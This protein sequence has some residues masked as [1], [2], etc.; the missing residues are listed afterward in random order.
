M[1]NGAGLVEGMFIPVVIGQGQDPDMFM[2]VVDGCAVHGATGGTG[3][4]GDNKKFAVSSWQLA[5]LKINCQPLTSN[6]ILSGTSIPSNFIDLLMT[7]P[8]AADS[9]SR[10]CFTASFSACSI[11]FS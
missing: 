11:D 6:Y 1:V 10:N 3:D 4:I 9:S 2:N 7:L 8:E 5:D